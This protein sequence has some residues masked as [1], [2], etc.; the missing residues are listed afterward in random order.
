M[1]GRGLRIGAMVWAIGNPLIV[2]ALACANCCMAEG[3]H[4]AAPVEAAAAHAPSC[5]R[6][7]ESVPVSDETLKST[8]SGP[9]ALLLAALDAQ[10]LVTPRASVMPVHL[11]ADRVIASDDSP[12]SLLAI[13]DS[14][15]PR[16]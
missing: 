12:T 4:P 2:P 6:S 1:I 16:T 7:A 5:H 9:A 14:P 11:A 15:P 3:A 8:C 10:G 13:P